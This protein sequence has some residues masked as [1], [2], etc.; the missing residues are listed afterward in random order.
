[1]INTNNYKRR[2][3]LSNGKLFEHLEQY[4]YRNHAN[5][6]RTS[7]S[8]W[9]RR[10]LPASSRSLAIFHTRDDLTIYEQ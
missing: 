1:M 2:T 4:Q 5:S 10:C 3:A 9:P 8:S 6:L 7:S